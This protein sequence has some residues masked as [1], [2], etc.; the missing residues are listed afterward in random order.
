MNLSCDFVTQF[1]CLTKSSYYSLLA[2]ATLQVRMLQLQVSA[3][4][5][6]SMTWPVHHFPLIIIIHFI[7]LKL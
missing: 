4:N 7:L 6:I 3:T 2:Y 1:H 5:C